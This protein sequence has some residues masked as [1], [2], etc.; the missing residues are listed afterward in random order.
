ML[1]E[2]TVPAERRDVL[3]G[4]L[5]LLKKRRLIR[6]FELGESERIVVARIYY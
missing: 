4:M 3:E 2:V 5:N 6:G 1:R